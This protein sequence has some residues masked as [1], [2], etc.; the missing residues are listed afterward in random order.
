M[1]N[2]RYFDKARVIAENLTEDMKILVL[3]EVNCND[4]E[5]VFSPILVNFEELSIF[6]PCTQV[7]NG[8]KHASYHLVLM[9]GPNV[10]GLGFSLQIS[11]LHI[12]V[13]PIKDS[14]DKVAL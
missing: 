7:L 10:D 1:L 2:G 5:K 14:Q 9:N 13:S 8:P 3:T 11:T 6:T 12:S 4:V